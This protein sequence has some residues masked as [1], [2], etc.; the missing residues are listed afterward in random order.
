MRGSSATFNKNF[1]RVCFHSEALGN[2]FQAPFSCCQS[3]QSFF[4]FDYEV[5]VS[6]WEIEQSPNTHIV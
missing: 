1:F 4:L 2:N 6:L 5:G 3:T